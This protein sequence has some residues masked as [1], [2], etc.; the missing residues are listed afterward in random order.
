M[1]IFI[2]IVFGFRNRDLTRVKRCLDSLKKQR[3]QNFEVVFVDYG[4][5]TETA[6]QAEKLVQSYDFNYIYSDS[7]F[8]FWSR[9]KALNIGIAN[10]KGE[11]IVTSDID[12]IFSDNFTEVISKRVQPEK[13]FCSQCFHLPENFDAYD[14]I[15]KYSGSFLKSG[16]TEMGIGLVVLKEKLQQIHG[17]EEYY[18]IWGVE[19]LDIKKRLESSGLEME[20]ITVEECQIYHQ[21]HPVVSHKNKLLTP[22]GWYETMWN[23]HS[24]NSSVVRNPDGWGKIKTS[25]DRPVLAF[26]ENKERIQ[27][28]PFV[29]PKFKSVNDFYHQFNALNTGEAIQVEFKEKHIPGDKPGISSKILKL[30]NVNLQKLRKTHQLVNT[31]ISDTNYINTS[32]VRDFLFYFIV[33]NKSS[34]KDYY[35]ESN[36]FSLKVLIVKS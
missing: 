17:F 8:T 1:N 29:F 7:R 34:I 24:N 10:A 11:F 33:N 20:Y 31:E 35:F 2:S 5:D 3:K 21:W 4:S 19:D 9:S 6:N 22:T 26:L 30:V 28:F 13:F 32:E 27:T 25:A 16:P 14:D 23:Y 12:A 15:R 36:E 18:Q